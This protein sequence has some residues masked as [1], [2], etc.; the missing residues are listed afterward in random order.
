M[1]TDV[2]IAAEFSLAP[3]TEIATKLGLDADDL[4][5]H[6]RDKAKIDP[7]VLQRPRSRPE[8]G[9]LVLVSAV[10]PTRAGEG[11]TTTS[12]GLG[13]GIAKLGESVCIALR[14]PSLGPCM[15]VKGGATGGGYSQVG[16]ADSIN[17]HFTGDFHAITAAHNLVAA[18]LD[19]KL[20]FESRL[21]IDPRK[22]L[23]PRVIDMNDRSLRNVVVGLGGS[24]QGVPR[25]TSFDIT[26]ASEIMAILCLS[27]DLDDLRA[28]IDRTIVALNRDGEPVTIADIGGT[29]AVCALLRDAMMPNLVQTLEGVPTIVHGGPFA[30]I[31]HGCNS[32]VA[33]RMAMHLADW[34]ITE[35]GFGFDLGAEKFL[36][37]KCVQAGLDPAAIVVV[38][39]IRALKMHGGVKRKQLKLE[40]VGAVSAGLPNLHKH[41]ESAAIFGKP[42]VVAINRFATDTD[43]EVAVVGSFCDSIGVR[44]AVSDHH[45]RGGEGAVDLARAVIATARKPT[46]PFT[47]AYERSD[48]VADKISS[49]ATK[50]Y[51]ADGVALSVQARRDIKR[52]G[53]LGLSHLPICIAKTQSSLSDNPKLRCRPTGF[54]INVAEI[55]LNAGAGFLVV[56]TGEIM[57]MPG[58]PRRPQANAIDLTEDGSIIGIA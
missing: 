29:G 30:N 8:P 44:W 12:I 3:I 21:A 13:Q 10:T 24:S 11:K 5:L 35:A 15:G 14:E 16:P 54:T 41:L 38:A 18:L 20:H 23:W 25:Q 56:M 51:G 52:I 49:V 43:A 40:D 48:S 55:R 45:G 50:I 53:E 6:G 46:A 7:A 22:V 26:A 32:V 19:N 47:P 36:D 39:T 37:I 17:L 1:P 4:H 33:T 28:R 34:T 9:R 31:A 57:R 42:A 58:L 2:E 27:R